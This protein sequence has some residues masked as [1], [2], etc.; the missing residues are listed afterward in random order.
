MTELD[1]SDG[2]SAPAPLLYLSPYV[3]LVSRDAALQ[4]EMIVGYTIVRMQPNLAR[5]MKHASAFVF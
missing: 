5:G 2:P 4:Q 1:L 3:P